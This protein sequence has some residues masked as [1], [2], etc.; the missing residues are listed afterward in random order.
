MRRLRRTTNEVIVCELP[1]VLR[2]RCRD[3]DEVWAGTEVVPCRCGS[4]DLAVE[5]LN[6]TLG[7][8]RRT[9]ARVAHLVNAIEDHVG[10]L[11]DT[12][13]PFDNQPRFA[14]SSV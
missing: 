10:H 2:L 7:E 12:G 9:E 6:A 13:K 8:L 1:D 11:T 5:S 3:C 4:D 14:Q